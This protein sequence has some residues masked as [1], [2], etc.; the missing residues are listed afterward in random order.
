M[1]L[2]L[3]ESIGRDIN[4]KAVLF[5]LAIIAGVALLM[6]GIIVLISKICHVEEDPRIAQV[7][8]LLAGANCGGC[9][10]PGCGGFACALCEGKADVS[11][12][13]PTSAENKAAICEILGMAAETGEPTIAV[14]ACAG[15]S[16]AVDK[17]AYEGYCDCDNQ[18]L[19][20]GGPKACTAGCMGGGTCVTA[21]PYGAIEIVDGCAKVKPEEC[22]SCGLCIKACPKNVITRIPQSA[23]IYIAC[24]SKCKGKDVMAQCKVGCIG[25]GICARMCPNG[26]ITMVDNLPVIDYSKCTS[27]HVCVAKCPRKIIRYVNEPVATESAEK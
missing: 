13:G 10:Y 9:G 20:A 2:L 6:G 16:N 3:L 18:I 11:A 27:C 15:G 22:R 24:N 23:S 7:T 1:Y 21:C 14:V 8:E 25:C 12:C 4:V 26:A 19:V 17:F 5:A